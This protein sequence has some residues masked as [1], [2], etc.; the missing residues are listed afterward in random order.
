[1]TVVGRCAARSQAEA[2]QL[3]ALEVAQELFPS[4]PYP[5]QA[6]LTVFTTHLGHGWPVAASWRSPGWPSRTG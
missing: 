3:L 6:L 4:P 2:S 1:M 5:F